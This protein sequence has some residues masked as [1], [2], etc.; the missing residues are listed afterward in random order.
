MRIKAKDWNAAMRDLCTRYP[1]SVQVENATAPEHAWTVNTAWDGDRK[2]W[3]A[4]VKA[5]SVNCKIATISMPFARSPESFQKYIQAINPDKEY[6]PDQ[7]IPV[8][9]DYLPVIDLSWREIGGDALPDGTTANGNDGIKNT[10]ETVPAYFRKRGVVPAQTTNPDPGLQRRLYACDL[11]LS[12][13]R[14]YLVNEITVLPGGILGGSIISVD[15]KPVTPPDISEPPT[16][17]ASAK[18][19]VP[20]IQNSFS[21][22]FFQRFLDEPKDD[23]H[24]STIYA[25]SQPVGT[26]L[27][28]GGVDETCTLETRYYCH[29]NLAHATQRVVPRLITPPLRLVTG[30]AAGLGD[31]MFNLILSTANDFAQAVLDL[32]QQRSLRGMFWVV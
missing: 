1:I 19:T 30:L 32:F 9:L 28:Q 22:I 6:K 13:P 26:S 18:Y 20:E 31:V 2:K 27:G 25:L 14:P 16:V 4:R 7:R 21:D 23:L 11:V 8:P 10:Y 24:L 5:G 17:Y 29:Y 3:T 12:M 15:A